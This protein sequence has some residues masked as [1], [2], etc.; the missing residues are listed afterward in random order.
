MTEEYIKYLNCVTKHFEA[1]D[2]YT[3]TI[4]YIGYGSFFAMAAFV[5]NYAT[6]KLFVISILVMTISIGIFTA[7]E[8]C[9]TSFYSYYSSNKA[10]SLEKLPDDNMLK[11]I[12][13]QYTVVS[14]FFQKYNIWF[15][16][17][18]TLLGIAAY[19]L[20]VINYIIILCR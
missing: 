14:I 16:M 1:M 12:D 9:R 19:V 6:K 3:T 17:P 4:A 10:E 7:H 20:M 15:F 5:K 13:N 8:L 18:S 11:S 2:K